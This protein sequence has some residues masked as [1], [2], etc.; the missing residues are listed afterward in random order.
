CFMIRPPWGNLENINKFRTDLLDHFQNISELMKKGE[1]PKIVQR[2]M[3][4]TREFFTRAMLA[5][6]RKYRREF[7]E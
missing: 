3:Q 5:F 7:V 4:K 2:E 6:R 1:D